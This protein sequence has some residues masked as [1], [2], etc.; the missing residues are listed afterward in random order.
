MPDECAVLV[1]QHF[2]PL[3]IVS[4]QRAL[5]MAR[6]LLNRY[7][8]VYVICGDYRRYDPAFLDLEYGKEVL[9][10]PRLVRLHTRPWLTRYGYG[11]RSSS[12]QRVL[13][14]AA[15]RVLCGPGVD[16]IPPLRRS[17]RRVPGAARVG[18]VLATGPPFITFPVVAGWAARRPAPV[19][20]DYRDLWTMN[21]QAR[22]PAIARAAVNRLIERRVN[23]AATLLTTVSEGCKAMIGVYSPGVPIRVLYNS[24]DRAYLEHYRGIVDERRPGA[25]TAGMA[26][27]DSQGSGPAGLRMVFTGQVYPGCTFVPLLRAMAALPPACSRQI[28]VHYYGDSSALV[29]AEFQQFGLADR[30]IDYGRVSKDDSVRAILG[31]GV[32]L[33]LIHTDHDSTSP[34]VTGLMTTKL[35]DY[36]LSSRPILNIGPVNAE[37]ATFAARAGSREFHSFTADDREGLTRFLERAVAGD[38][39]APREPLSVSL[40][41]FEAQ[42][43]A[44]VDEATAP[45]ATTRR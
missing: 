28:S 2:L 15:T 18:V 34:A 29:R 24:P 9:Q 16:W 36:L 11:A 38:L 8:L 26:G 7:G 12:V 45:R 3:N 40:P 37:A 17:L 42:L 32:L 1:A 14:G 44:V 31:A 23:R 33:S 13:G 25:S 4:A 35:Y 22:Y 21:P 27:P 19:I 41:D 10:D 5:R 20:L 6:A 30:L 43:H 39:A